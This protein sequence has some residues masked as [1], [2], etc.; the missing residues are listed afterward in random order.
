M[1]IAAF[2]PLLSFFVMAFRD[3]LRLNA[4]NTRDTKLRRV[5]EQHCVEEADHALWFLSD[6]RELC[7]REPDLESLFGA[8]HATTRDATYSVIAEVLRTDSDAERL[9]VL[10]ALE[11][12][13][14]AF[15]EISA[16]YFERTGATAWSLYFS[17]H[18]LDAEREHELAQ[19]DMRAL[20]ASIPLGDHELGRAREVVEHIYQAICGMLDGCLSAT[21]SDE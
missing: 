19:D 9:A 21:R 8:R 1:Q 6:V 12:I 15:F 17:Q 10:L 16:P 4:K 2:V 18:H 3:V 5:F 13:S 20:L 11:A 14:E 7:G